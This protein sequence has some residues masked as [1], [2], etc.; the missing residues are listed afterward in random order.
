MGNIRTIL[1]SLTA[2][3]TISLIRVSNVL[4]EAP[5]GGISSGIQAARGEG[6]PSDLFGSSG[7][8]TTVVNVLLF[9]IGAVAVIMIIV[10]GFRYII[11]GGNANSVTAAKNTILYA[12]VGVVVALLAYAAIEFVV[13]S[14]SVNTGSG[15]L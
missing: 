7:I 3:M 9:I 10:G 13:S 12:V 15:D 11:S 2:V 1:G 6:Q 4:A 14:F 5:S 8:F